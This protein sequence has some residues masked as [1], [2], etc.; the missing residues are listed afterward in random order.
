MSRI[1][2]DNMRVVYAYEGYGCRSQFLNDIVKFLFDWQIKNCIRIE[3]VYIKTDVNAADAPSR[4]INIDN[5]MCI[6]PQFFHQIEQWFQVTI[7]L[8]T[9]A[10]QGTQ[11]TTLCGREI[12]YCSQYVDEHNSHLNFFN[13][14]FSTLMDEKLWIFAPRNQEAAF[15]DFFLSQPKRPEAIVILLQHQEAPTLLNLLRRQCF[16]L[17]VFRGR[18]LFRKPF[19]KRCCFVP[20]HGRLVVHCFRLPK[21]NL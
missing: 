17:R 20:Y 18:G 11:I 5:E 15:L 3:I 14:P 21:L 19:A 12:P 1:H 4:E 9:C 2:C 13:L 10:S 8:D 7:T 6:T 16:E